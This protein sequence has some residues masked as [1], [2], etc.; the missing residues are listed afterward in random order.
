MTL[1]P[2]KEV[3][4]VAGVG[5]GTGAA[6]V[7]KFA[8]EGCSVAMLA[9]SEAF[10]HRLADESTGLPGPLMSLP[11]DIADPARVQ[12]VFGHVRKAMGLTTLLVNHASGGSWNGLMDTNL[13]NMEH[14]WRVSVLGAFNCCKAAVPQMLEAGRGTIIF[15]GATSSIRGRAGA[16]DFTTAKFG[17]R[18]LAWSLAAEFTARGIHVA[19]AIVDG[20]IE[21]PHSG[22]DGGPTLTPEAIADAY[23]AISRQDPRAWTWE[24]DLR[25]R[26][27]AFFE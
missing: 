6:I 19:H 21:T 11:C 15:T 22:H 8:A 1:K 2:H 3:V 13:A 7:R 5:E 4:V 14:A 9:R 17:V 18:G 20:V 27:E 23:W 24:F 10:L 12:E 26:G 16:L 25:P